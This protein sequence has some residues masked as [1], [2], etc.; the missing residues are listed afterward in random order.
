ME[1]THAGRLDPAH[2]DPLSLPE[3]VSLAVAD[4]SFIS[5]TR[6]LR[7]I[8][9]QL[10]PGG[11]I[12]ALVKPQFEAGREAVSKGVV[13][14]PAVQRAAVDG[15]RRH[16]EELGLLVAGEIESPLLGPAGN[17]EFLLHLVGA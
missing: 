5:L 4:V 17:R 6:V 8:Q 15:V 1:K 10:A 13:R 11:E 14:D 16:A 12:I 2:A 7:G 3:K 9:A